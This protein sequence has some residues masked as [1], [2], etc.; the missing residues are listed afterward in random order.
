MTVPFDFKD[1]PIDKITKGMKVTYTEPADKW[2][3]F[4]TKDKST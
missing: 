4:L 1:L 3:E 2:G